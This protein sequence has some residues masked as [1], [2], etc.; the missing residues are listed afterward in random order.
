MFR[1]VSV[2]LADKDVNSV[3]VFSGYVLTTMTILFYT[4]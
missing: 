2:E 1:T 4:H 3:L